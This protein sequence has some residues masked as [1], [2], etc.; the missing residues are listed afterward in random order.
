MSSLRK[1]EVVGAEGLADVG[2]GY[3]SHVA[4]NSSISIAYLT[5]I[6]R[7]L[8]FIVGVK[9]LAACSIGYL[10]NTENDTTPRGARSAESGELS[11]WPGTP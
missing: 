8:S 3:R 6:G 5:A 2:M 11:R 1:Q 10:G 9:L 7:R 4:Y